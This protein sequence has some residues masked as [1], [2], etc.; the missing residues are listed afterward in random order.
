MAELDTAPKV[1]PFEKGYKIGHKI[2]FEEGSQSVP[3]VVQVNAQHQLAQPQMKKRLPGVPDFLRSRMDTANTVSHRPLNM[4]SDLQ[5]PFAVAAAGG[6][7]VAV[8]FLVTVG[9]G[10]FFF[11]DEV[12]GRTYAQIFW[13][14][15]I[16]GIGVAIANWFGTA[17]MRL[18]ATMSLENIL[19]TDIDG[20]GVVGNPL[21]SVDAPIGRQMFQVADGRQVYIDVPLSKS[22]VAA[23]FAKLRSN[24]WHFSR[25]QM[26]GT[27]SQKKANELSVSMR[28]Y[29]F[30][31]D[32]V[33]NELNDAGRGFWA[34]VAKY[35]TSPTPPPH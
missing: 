5:T 34:S 7:L 10:A 33:N 8:A 9:G 25:N 24:G 17:K 6:A 27:I 29:D 30:F 19:N 31:S 35:A 16:A 3:D 1:H 12:S 15:T 22:E 20:D 14:S 11:V 2:G 4:H 23:V 32:S 18:F 13:V 21:D 26:A 28:Y